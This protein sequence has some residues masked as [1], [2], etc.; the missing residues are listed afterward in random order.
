MIA[1]EFGPD[2]A[3]LSRYP[4]INTGGKTKERVK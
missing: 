1:M 4:A 2:W 3:A